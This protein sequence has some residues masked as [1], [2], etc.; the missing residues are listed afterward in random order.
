MI[1]QIVQCRAA[2]TMLMLVMAFTSAIAQRIPDLSAYRDYPVNKIPEAK[3][4]ELKA[5][6]NSR[7]ISYGQFVV[8]A[9]NNGLSQQKANAIVSRMQEDASERSNT[10][11][12]PTTAAPEQ[13]PSI[14]APTVAKAASGGTSEIFGKDLF[15]KDNVSFQPNVNMPTPANYVLGPGDEVVIDVWGAAKKH[16]QL[17]VSK[18]GFIQLENIGPIYVTGLSLERAR[19]RVTSRL[20][21]LYRGLSGAEPNTFAQVY[22]GKIRTI[23]VTV[24][25]NAEVP[26]TYTLPSI[27]TV[28]HGLYASGGPNEQ[29][30]FRKVQLIRYNRKVAELDLYQYLMTGTAK[31]NQFLR[32]GDIILIPS[33]DRRVRISGEVLKEGLFELKEGESAEALLE[34][35][36]GY[37]AWAYTK[38]IQL[39]RNTPRDRLVKDIDGKELHK[40]PLKNGD[41][42][43][44]RRIINRFENRVKLVGALQMPGSYEIGKNTTLLQVIQKAEGLHQNA[45]LGRALLMRYTESYTREAQSINLQ[46]LLEGKDTL[47]LQ[48][49][50]V[51]H[52]YFIDELQEAQKVQIEGA[53]QSGGEYTFYTGMT[54]QDLIA[55]AGGLTDAAAS[56]NIEVARRIRS[57]EA[58]EET[59]EIF[60]FQIDARLAGGNDFALE[61][62]D[63]VIVRRAPGYQRQHT[64]LIE[65]EVTYPGTYVI[66]SKSEK[67]SALIQRAGGV[68]TLADLNGARLLRS[69]ESGT[70][71]VGIDLHELLSGADAVDIIIKPGDRIIIPSTEQTITIEGAVL[72]PI[73]LHYQPGKRLKH[74]V[75]SSGGYA[76]RAQKR[77]IYV[78]NAN[79]TSS[80]V[81]NYV[82]FKKYPK[83]EAGAT[84][85]IPYK[86]ERDKIETRDVVSIST[87][88]ATLSLVVISVIN[89]LNNGI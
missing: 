46:E 9:T 74:Y 38:L 40:L 29:G 67:L 85:H 30:S 15:E 12:T 60:S 17:M 32:D 66:Q 10:T 14:S 87:G 31:G 33:Y 11:T 72:N 43:H 82:L 42:I 55:Q 64:V 1:K 36:G 18:E 73:A 24:M 83:V 51:V 34:F 76:L 45:F 20:S 35:S 54:L 78:V 49:D 88:V 16:Y 69:A 25:G 89:A 39:E 48:A 84:I 52:V 21:E 77:K 63:Y 26:G 47:V 44:V 62:Y 13:A 56:N 58:T 4:S 37:T 57:L 41:Q 59:A 23:K 61:P 8:L 53:V 71:A 6:L 81:R 5:N 75:N 80:R 19:S 86:P 3:I 27:S 22:I 7:N 79:N 68:T 50:D 2:C 70:E 28:F 65:G